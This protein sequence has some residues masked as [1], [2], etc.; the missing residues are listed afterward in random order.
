LAP[1]F[2]DAETAEDQVQDIVG[3]GGAGNFVQRAEGVVEV[4]QEHFVGH[5]V[6][7]GGLSSAQGCERILHQ[8]LVAEVG[9]EA[10]IGLSAGVSTDVAKDFGAQLGDSLAG[11]GGCLQTRRSRFLAS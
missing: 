6:L 3:S 11:K 5:F 8:L 4:E 2:S 7:H 9:Q 10:C 1:L